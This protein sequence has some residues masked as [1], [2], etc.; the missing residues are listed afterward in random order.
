MDKAK[1]ELSPSSESILVTGGAG[2]I[3]SHVVDR[4]LGD[5]RRV[6]CIDN[7]DSFY[8][9]LIK[10]R[11]VR[12]HL[13][14]DTYELVEG[15]IRNRTDLEPIFRRGGVRQVLH[16]AARA[17]VRPS[18]QDPLLY[19][20]VNVKGTLNLLELAKEHGVENFVFASSSSVYGINA[21]VPFSETD[22]VSLPISPYAA[23]KRA[24]ELLCYT[25]HHLYGIPISCLRFFTVYGPRQRPEM[26]I[27]MFARLIDEGGEV[28]MFGDGTSRRD[29][30]F[31]TDIV[32]GVISAMNQRL[33]Y[34]IINLGNSK[35][36]ELK[37]LISLIET[38]LGKKARVRNMPLQP[39]DV[40]I[41]YADVATAQSLLGY[42]PKVDIEEGIE[43]FVQWYRN[44]QRQA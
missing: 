32:N 20:D 23:T 15:D 24:G 33:G 41:T 9:P 7:F 5:G 44:N 30:T 19:E 14:Q 13:Q 29:Y 37:R 35:T 31:I 10:R 4:L 39:G 42:D 26:A 36:I 6:I 11:N 12:N 27:H 25:Y 22:D 17:G 8:D 18:I 21:K 3:G 16:L 28:E 1:A 40:P 43:N 34:E 2:F 38:A